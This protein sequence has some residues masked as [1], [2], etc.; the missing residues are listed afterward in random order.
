MKGGLKRDIYKT[1][2]N[3]LKLIYKEISILETAKEKY[4]EKFNELEEIIKDKIINT[5]ENFKNK[6]TTRSLQKEKNIAIVGHSSFFGQFKDKH[7]PYKEN[8]DEEL[9]HCHP[10]E[11]LLTSNYRR[12]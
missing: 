6:I 4:N 1:L 2:Q 10:Y 3:N 11:F 5:T 8:G 9:K 7:I 12:S